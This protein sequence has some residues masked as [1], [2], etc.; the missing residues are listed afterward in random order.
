MVCALTL[1][2]CTAGTY[3]GSALAQ[4]IQLNTKTALAEETKVS[5]LKKVMTQLTLLQQQQRAAQKLVDN[6]IK[7][8]KAV[9]KVRKYSGKTWYVFSGSSPYGWDCSGLVRWTYEQMGVTLEHSATKQMR[10][11]KTVEKPVIGDIVAF[12]YPGS[13]SSFHVGIYVGNGKMIHSYRPGVVTGIE[14]VARV[15]KDNQAKYKYVRILP[16]PAVITATAAGS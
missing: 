3:Q 8:E 14:S 1:T 5:P 11:G 13:K 16:Q 7:I 10:S 6:K 2:A 15:A 9:K 12:Y 4:T